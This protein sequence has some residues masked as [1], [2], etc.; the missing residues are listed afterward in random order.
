[1]WA[2]L[3]KM[4][5]HGQLWF[6]VLLPAVSLYIACITQYPPWNL[7]LQAQCGNKCSA[8][9]HGTRRV[10]RFRK[11]FVLLAF[12]IL[13]ECRHFSAYKFVVLHITSN[14]YSYTL[15]NIYTT[16]HLECTD[17][18]D[19]TGQQLTFET[20]VKTSTTY[21]VLEALSISFLKDRT[22]HFETLWHTG[23]ANS[24]E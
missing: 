22:Q 6:L 14:Y 21:H 16:I 24:T 3:L 4:L 19:R 7:Q 11:F 12:Y 13:P 8:H 2:A 18:T 5:K 17:C 20:N 9:L 23:K 1:M 10:G 15:T